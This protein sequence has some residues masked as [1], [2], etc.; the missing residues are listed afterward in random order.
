MA[1][2][3]ALKS[4][5]FAA[6]PLDASHSIASWLEALTHPSALIELATLAACIVLAWL[7]VRTLS[8]RRRFQDASVWFGERIVDGVLFPLLLLSLAFA[9]QELLR[10]R[11]PIAVFKVAIPIL[12]AL[13]LI[14]LGVKVL[15]VAY[16]NAPLVRALERT[17]SWLIWLAL[18]LWLTGLMPLMLEQ[19]EAIEWKVGESYLSLRTLLE[20]VV[21]AGVVLLIALWISAAIETR[22]LRSASGGDLSLRKAASNASR[23]ILM[24]VGVLLAVSAVGIDLTALSVLGG[25]IGV[26]V[27][28]GLQKLV[29]SYVSGFVILAER[30]VRIGDNVKV[31][32][33]EG[34]IIDIRARYT[35]VRAANGRDAIV[36]NE[37]FINNRVE[38]L[39][40]FDTRV[41]LTSVVTVAFDSDAAQVMRLLQGAAL[42]HPR[43]IA[44]PAPAANLSALGPDGLQFTLEY[45]IADAENGQQN[46][47]SLVNL[48]VLA[49]LRAH[50][51]AIA[52]PQRAVQGVAPAGL[53][54]QPIRSPSTGL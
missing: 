10:G 15:Q 37:L 21:T 26:G 7:L 25:A 29:S 8:R 35:V 24:F 48:D 43:V 3:A 9:A 11:L 38:N 18:V 50:R 41:M 52:D 40:F 13:A 49:G 23:V 47:R 39:S 16:K 51:I 42:K 27:G 14:R 33:F 28:L 45:W 22:L 12:L 4:A 2:I 20:G 19:L 32:T 34:R 31:D 6:P 1:G 17:I 53:P 44:Q 54:A 36:P 46:L 30:S 5:I